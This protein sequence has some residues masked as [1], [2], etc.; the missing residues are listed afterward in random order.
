MPRHNGLPWLAHEIAAMQE[1]FAPVSSYR[2]SIPTKALNIC[3]PNSAIP[4]KHAEKNMAEKGR[5]MD[6]DAIRAGIV[7]GLWATL[8]GI[9]GVAQAQSDSSSLGFIPVTPIW[10]TSA[11]E[12]ITA[13]YSAKRICDAL[14]DP[15]KAALK[16]FGLEGSGLAEFDCKTL[17]DAVEPKRDLVGS[18]RSKT[19]ELVKKTIKLLGD[20]KSYCERKEDEKEAGKE[21]EQEKQTTCLALSLAAQPVGVKGS[22]RIAAISADEEDRDV[23]GTAR[24][25]GEG[26]SKSPATR[27]STMSGARS[28]R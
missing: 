8:A 27:L 14:D 3:Q 18:G 24:S 15:K 9:C 19:T 16:D 1:P 4:K 13:W 12:P 28:I 23:D 11:G 17:R 7:A 21:K 5:G 25:S 10:S 20:L 6:S 22:D 2:Y 26:S